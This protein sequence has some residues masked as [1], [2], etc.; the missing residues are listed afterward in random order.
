MVPVVRSLLYSSALAGGALL[1]CMPA[2]AQEGGTDDAMIVV[3]GERLERTLRETASSV[4]IVTADEIEAVQAD[5]VD[6]ILALIPNVQIGAGDAAPSIRG[7]DATGVLQGVDAFFG[8]GRPRATIRLDGRDLGF[9]ELVYGL[10]SVWDVARIEVFRSPQTTTQGRNSIAG[11]I[12]IETND[13]TY[14]WEGRARALAG[15]FE[16]YQ[17]SGVVSGPLVEDQLAI[18]VAADYGDSESWSVVP[19]TIPGIDERKDRFGSARVKILAEPASIPGMRLEVTYQ[20]LESDAPQGETTRIPFERRENPTGGGGYFKTN[21]DS[22]T[23]VLNLDLGGDAGLRLTGSYGD[24]RIDRL[25]PPGSG[26]ITIDVEDFSIEGVINASPAEA[27]DTVFGIYY[28]DTGQDELSDLSLFL[29]LGDFRDDQTSLGIFGEAAVA[30]TPRLT[31]TVGGRYQRDTQDRD[32][33][34]GTPVF[35]FTVDYDRSFEAFLPKASLAFDI[36]PDH[37]VGVLAQRAFN[38]GGT[39][40]SFTTGEQDFFEDERLWNYELFYRASFLNGRARFNANLFY[41]DFED[42]QR[43]QT[44]VIPV[45]GGGEMLETNIDNAPDAESYGLEAEL[46]L[47]ATPRLDL[48]FGLGLLATEITETLSPADPILDRDFQ[49]APGFSLVATADWRPID[50]LRIAAQMRHNDGYFSDDANTAALRVGSR[51]VVDARAAYTFG[52]VTV[53]AFAENLFDDFYLTQLYAP[54][55]GTAG[56]PFEYGAGIEFA[57]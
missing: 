6:D 27:I 13:P 28:L 36:T 35:G 23:G 46:T 19:D 43:P 3:T 38:P 56:D 17:L 54:D 31:A 41:T 21:V 47:A 37:T 25:S 7:Q 53:F 10:S 9:N 34:L 49:R 24:S 50:G 29:G 39:T 52:G 15:N 5:R 11:A 1:S 14:E 42:A 18:R 4:D 44:L 26:L 40:I 20:H 32:G 45:P 30:L 55:F 8:G 22:L 2:A 57:F 16:T 12:F 51:T 48:G 33:F